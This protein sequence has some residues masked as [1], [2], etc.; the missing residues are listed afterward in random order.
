MTL[1]MN[2]LALGL[3]ALV[4]GCAVG[5]DYQR[6]ATDLPAAYDMP[7]SKPAEAGVSALNPQWWKLFHDPVLDDIVAKALVNNSDLQLA[8]ARVE[9]ADALLR[10][11][12]STLFPEIDVLGND[13]RSRL[14][15]TTVVPGANPLVREDMKMTVGTS[16][17]LDLW[18]RLRRGRESARADELA[19]RYGRDTVRLTVAGLVSQ[20]YIA[21]R[22]LD[23]QVAASRSTLESREKAFSIARTRLAAGLAS[24]LDLRQAE[25][26]LAA[27]KSQTAD[28]VQQR[29][30]AEHQLA[31]LVGDMALKLPAGDLGKLPLPPVPPAGLP[32]SLLEARPDVRQAEEKLAAANARIGMAKA[33]LFPTISLTGNLGGESAQLAGL[34][35]GASK[36][37][38]AGFGLSLP[39]FT[40]GRL[41]AQVDQ[42][43]AQQKQAL[44][45]YQKAVQS[46]FKDVKDALVSLTQT[47]E[48]DEAL[49]AQVQAAKKSLSLAQARYEAGYSPFLEVLDA[50]RTANDATQSALR[51]RQARLS[52]SVDLFKAL[53]G[54]WKE[55]P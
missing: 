52:A 55:T 12:G 2:L 4:S 33:A 45:G 5:P 41:S 50:Q 19:S 7:A 1:R 47:G 30:L 9:E 39:I 18:G 6:P 21:V 36:I 54:G 8:V 48:K 3:A 14:S 22:A 35:G 37:W 23:A 25:S 32:S 16:F 13:S 43:T 27:A 17:E 49:G 38:T 10:Q 44:A 34:F 20:G 46:A 51:N 53:G 28:L 40:A 24:E 42:A 15:T 31:L 26:A 29:A 11:A